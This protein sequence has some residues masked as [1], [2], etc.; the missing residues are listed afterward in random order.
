LFHLRACL[1]F[2][3]DFDLK[4]CLFLPCAPEVFALLVSDLLQK[5]KKFA[6]SGLQ[7]VLCL[8][9]LFASELL[10]K[11]GLGLLLAATALE[12]LLP[13]AV[14]LYDPQ[15]SSTKV[16]RLVASLKLHLR[17]L[18]EDPALSLHQR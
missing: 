9:S 8:R 6:A 13:A 4:T 7:K 3:S 12:R 1:E 2:A 11:L 16:D 17:V 18:G 10:Q 14:S 15:Q 5:K